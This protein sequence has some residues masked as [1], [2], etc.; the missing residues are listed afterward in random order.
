[1]AGVVVALVVT[2]LVVACDS[3]PTLLCR[4]VVHASEELQAVQP[5]QRDCRATG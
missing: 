2:A 1:M 4:G 5:K 3:A